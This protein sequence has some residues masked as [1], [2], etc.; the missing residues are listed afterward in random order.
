MLH[1]NCNPKREGKK[2]KL[3][4]KARLPIAAVVGDVAVEYS[5]LDGTCSCMSVLWAA[6][7]AP[8]PVARALG[9]GQPVVRVY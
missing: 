1:T 7:A 5:K 6:V 2:P 9:V 3:A 4:E 8:P